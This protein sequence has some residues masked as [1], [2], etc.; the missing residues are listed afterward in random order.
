MNKAMIFS[1]AL[2]LVAAIIML[3]TLYFKF[4]AAP[5]S[6]FIFSSLGI[7]PWGR[8]TIGIA[9]LL[10]AILLLFP[11]TVLWG[12]LMGFGIMVGAVASH[13]FVLGISVMDDGGQLFIYGLIVLFA[14]SILLFQNRAQLLAFKP[15]LIRK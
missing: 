12:A 14:C 9:E 4:T 5:E 7:E 2:R 3:Q 6:V 8:I 11:A 1:W 10:A 15:K 13:L